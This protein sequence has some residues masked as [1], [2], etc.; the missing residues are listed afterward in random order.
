MLNFFY[1]LLYIILKM[2]ILCLARPSIGS[3]HGDYSN[4]GSA[5]ILF[6]LFATNKTELNFF[7]CH[8]SFAHEGHYL[9]SLALPNDCTVHL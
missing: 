1:L 3:I 2:F 8:K 6:L 5:C 4:E 9:K 7:Q